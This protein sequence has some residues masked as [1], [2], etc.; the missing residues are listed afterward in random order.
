MKPITPEKSGDPGG[1]YGALAR[2]YDAF[3]ENMD[4]KKRVEYL[5]TLFSAARVPERAL[6]LDLACGSGTYA[7]AL[8]EKGYDVIGVDASLEMLGAAL[9]KAEK[10]RCAPPLLL[11]QRLET[12][13]LYGTAQ[14]AICLTDSIN[15]L[16]EPA[17]LQRFFKRLA[18]FLEPGAAFIFDCN[19]PHKHEAVLGDNCFLYESQNA[20]CAWQNH[21]LPERRCTEIHLDLFAREEDGSYSRSSELFYERVYETQELESMLR[22]A[23]FEVEHVYEELTQRLPTPEAERL[24]FVARRK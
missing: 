13:D 20:F 2:F 7:Y 8:L 23:G 14:A 4:Y 22:K 1:A 21:W 16:T 3:T 11:C 10:L 9:A 19:T 6:V 15:H 18:L 17:Q 12:L 5:C 24:F